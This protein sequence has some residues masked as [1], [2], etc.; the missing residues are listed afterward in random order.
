M[1]LSQFKELASTY[2]RIPVYIKVTADL[3][4]PVLAYLKL[5][6]RDNH[7]FLLESVEGIGRLARY[8]F[9]GVNPTRVIMNKGMEITIKE[10]GQVKQINQ[11]LFH[12]LKEV[13]GKVSAPKL[14][15]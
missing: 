2:N 4:T 15:E 9:I 7:C 8:S 13:I 3:L 14:D 1:E 12:Y 10:K 5:R 6:D 11:N